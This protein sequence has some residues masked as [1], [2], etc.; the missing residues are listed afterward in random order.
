M[1]AP[2]FHKINILI[3]QNQVIQNA[4]LLQVDATL[5][6]LRFYRT[7]LPHLVRFAGVSRLAQ[8]SHGSVA[9]Q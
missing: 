4:V 6:M 1:P 9:Y 3:P 2:F 8:N 5:T 7:R